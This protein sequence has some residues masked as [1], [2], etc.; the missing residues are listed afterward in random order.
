[1][2]F[3]SVP[4]LIAAI[5]EY[6]T[7]H[8]TNPKPFIWTKS[9]RDILQKVIR[10]NSRLSSKQN[11][12]LACFNLRD[13]PRFWRALEVTIHNFHSGYRQASDDEW[14]PTP[15]YPTHNDYMMAKTQPEHVRLLKAARTA[16]G[17]KALAAQDGASKLAEA[18]Q[19]AETLKF[20]LYK[21]SDTAVWRDVVQGAFIA[22]V[23]GT[24]K[25]PTPTR[26]NFSRKGKSF[27]SFLMILK[28]HLDASKTRRQKTDPAVL[29]IANRLL[30][31]P[32]TKRVQDGA[33]R[34]TLED[35][36]THL[37]RPR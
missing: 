26:Y 27:N 15:A 12:T 36:R 6:I 9:A 35:I 2:V 21:K 29:M 20:R 16:K 22:W 8:N 24:G 3:T 25:L 32:V 34:D 1:G 28:D 30:D 5:D 4:E 10:A 7:H 11:A 13:D 23:N 17:K 19:V 14:R 31:E 18:K 33:I 37:R